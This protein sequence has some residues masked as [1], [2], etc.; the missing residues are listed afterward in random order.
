[1]RSKILFLIVVLGVSA[2]TFEV[3]VETPQPE[4]SL[5]L[6]PSSSATPQPS[7]VL[8]EIASPTQALSVATAASGSPY[9]IQFSPNATWQDLV[10]SIDSGASKTYLLYALEGQVMS[11]SILPE[12]NEQLGAFQLEIEGQNG[13]VLCPVKDYGCAFWRGALPASQGYFITVTAQASGKFTLHVV[14]NPPGSANQYFDYF[15]PQRKLA[16]SYSDLFAPAHYVGG[17]ISKFEP[18]LTLE[19]IDS[20][21]YVQT[22]LSEAYF[23]LGL[24]DDPQQVSTCTQPI[25][26]GGPETVVGEVEIN[27]ITFTRSEVQGAAAGNIYEQ[28]YHRAAH[29]GVCYEITFFVHYANIGVYAPG[30][31]KEFDRAV[32]LQKFDQILSTLVFR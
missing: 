32:L 22:N 14:I 20:Q 8:T 6:L 29:N 16:L 25:S 27:G 2:C 26:L 15:N 3:A 23:L 17:S 13:E 5:P 11:I 30:T 1:M 4:T 28:I 7:S 21:Q 19:F 24:S 31:V 18:E 10:D 9:Q 12:N